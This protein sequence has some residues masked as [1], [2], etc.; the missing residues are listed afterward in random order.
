MVS[1]DDLIPQE[2]KP[3]EKP[4]QSFVEGMKLGAKKRALGIAEL[5]TNIVNDLG[6]APES[7]AYAK[8][9]LADVGQDY[10]RQGTGTGVKGAI[11]EI[12]GDPLS[13]IPAASFAKILGQGALMG[14]TSYT[15]DEQS[16]LINNAFNTAGGALASATGYGIGRGISRIAKPVN[17]SLNTAAKKAITTLEK[18]GV[19]LS[20]AQKTG[21]RALAGLE[22]VFSTLPTT[23]AK[24]AQITEK[25]RNAFTKAVLSKAGINADTASREVLDKASKAFGD[26]YAALAKNNVMNVDEPLLEGVAK[27]YDDATNGVLGVD[28]SS[29]VKKVAKDIFEAKGPIDGTVYQKTRSMLTQA[30]QSA[31]PHEAGVLKTL[32]NELDA[33]FE[34]SLPE[35]QRGI[36]ADINRRYQSFKPIQSAMESVSGVTGEIDPLALYPKVNVG[37]PLSDLADAGRNILPSKIPDSGTA[38]RTLMQNMITG[39]GVAGAGYGATSDSGLA[40]YIGAMGGTLAGPRAAQYIYNQPWAQRYLIE[41]MAKPIQAGANAI[42]AVLPR[43]AA[44]SFS[45]SREDEFKRSPA[46]IEVNPNPPNPYA[47]GLDFNDLIPQQPMQQQQPLAPQSSLQERI[48]QAESSGNPNAQNP[49]S[50]ASGLYQFTN[51]TWRS[52]VDK[53]GRRSGIRYSDKNN[54][55]A[56]EQMVAAL[57]QDNARI[58]QNK[59]IEPSDANLYFAHFMGAPAASKAISMLGKNAIAARSFPDAAKANP[60]VF[61][62]GQRPR[63]VDEVYQIITSKVV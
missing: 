8:A 24:Q 6:I 10:T 13:Y 46:Q 22:A 23:S 17:T 18:A 25:Q 28:A 33:A 48:K 1:F 32:R 15:G 62:D 5:G 2:K 20:A 21:S 26:E 60:T 44:S 29:M 51:D 61:F 58:L 53:F 56:Q 34:R 47:P 59:G 30:S 4:E 35:S 14:G 36:M 42:S 12:A 55:Q 39:V 52:V 57:L 43:A 50:S 38:Q 63:T 7:T 49:L 45:G 37:A 19:P 9:L 3:P 27:A 16:N 41:G 11:A 31:K 40:P 54:P